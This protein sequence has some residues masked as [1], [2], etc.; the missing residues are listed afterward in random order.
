[1]TFKQSKI[2]ICAAKRLAT[3]GLIKQ[4]ELYAWRSVGTVAVEALPEE[5]YQFEGVRV[6]PACRQRRAAR[7]G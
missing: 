5:S 3:E 4:H 1:M 7:W 2:H 6:S